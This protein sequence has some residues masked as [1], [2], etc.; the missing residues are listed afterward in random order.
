MG[1]HYLLFLFWVCF[2]DDAIEYLFTNF[3]GL[4]A[5]VVVYLSKDVAGLESGEVFNNICFLM[6]K[7]LI[8]RDCLKV[9]FD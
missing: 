5:I 1:L 6:W 8:L 7:S 9:S 2:E 3:T 4:V